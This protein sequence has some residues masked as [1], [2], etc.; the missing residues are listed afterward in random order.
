MMED[1]PSSY[2]LGHLLLWQKPD[3]VKTDL[4][5][6]FLG[7]GIS[8]ISTSFESRLRRFLGDVFYLPLVVVSEYLLRRK[9]M[10]KEETMLFFCEREFLDRLFSSKFEHVVPFAFNTVNL[11]ILSSFL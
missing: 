9:Q 4:W 7:I 11:H 8:N 2:S 3:Q 6:L 5:E 10:R 1:L